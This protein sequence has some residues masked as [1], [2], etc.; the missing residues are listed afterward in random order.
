MFQCFFNKLNHKT[1]VEFFQHDF[2]LYMM[3]VWRQPTLYY[4]C[5]G[6]TCN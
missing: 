6:V 4:Q 1:C 3:G 2:G 5:W